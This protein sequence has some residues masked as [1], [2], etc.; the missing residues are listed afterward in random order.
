[1]GRDFVYYIED[2]LMDG[3]FPFFFEPLPR[4]TVTLVTE[5]PEYFTYPF[6]DVVEV[7]P[8]VRYDYNSALNYWQMLVDCKPEPPCHGTTAICVG[9]LSFY[10]EAAEGLKEYLGTALHYSSL[11]EDFFTVPLE[12]TPGPEDYWATQPYSNINQ[13]Q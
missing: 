4:R 12:C 2:L 8:L 9:R 3:L 7:H 10:K 5:V 13:G 6:R 1:M 11:G